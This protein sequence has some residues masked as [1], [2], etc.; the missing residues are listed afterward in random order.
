LREQIK[1]LKNV[2]TLPLPSDTAE[3]D[4]DE[5]KSVSGSKTIRDKKLQQLSF[6]SKDAPKI[7]TKQ[8]LQN[9]KTI[10]PKSQT[11]LLTSNT[12]QDRIDFVVKMWNNGQFNSMEV[13][14][15][16]PTISELYKSFLTENNSDSDNND[17]NNSKSQPNN[18]EEHGLDLDNEEDLAKYAQTGTLQTERGRKIRFGDCVVQFRYIVKSIRSIQ[19]CCVSK[20]ERLLQGGVLDDE[21]EDSIE[22]EGDSNSNSGNTDSEEDDN[23]D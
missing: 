5:R 2:K 3:D 20:Q 21:K 11:K 19:G 10:V 6:K 23:D 4:D 18:E 16:Q 22:S 8:V 17:D 13:T 7:T 14:F 1:M 9:A 12:F 15:D